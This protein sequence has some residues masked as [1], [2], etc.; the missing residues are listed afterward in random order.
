M[1]KYEIAELD[2]TH[3]TNNMQVRGQGKVLCIKTGLKGWFSWE[4]ER[5]PSRQDLAKVIPITR[6]DPAII[7]RQLDEIKGGI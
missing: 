4:L 1:E 2:F 5:Y 7:Y 6:L 3:V